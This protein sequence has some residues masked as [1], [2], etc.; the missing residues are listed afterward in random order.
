MIY[1]TLPQPMESPIRHPNHL[2]IPGLTIHQRTHAI[3]L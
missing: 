3:F 2:I 1:I